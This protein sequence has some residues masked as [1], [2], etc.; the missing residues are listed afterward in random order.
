MNQILK[1]LLF[2]A[3]H[4]IDVG[5]LAQKLLCGY[6]TICEAPHASVHDAK[7][8]EVLIDAFSEF[9]GEIV[10][11]STYKWIKYIGDLLSGNPVDDFYGQHFN[12]DTND[13]D[14]IINE[15]SQHEWFVNQMRNDVDSETINY[16]PE[17]AKTRLDIHL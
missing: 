10:D 17:I 12:F 11:G 13:I 9:D 14:Q 15:L 2:E 6:L 4:D 8:H 7:G 3:T 1:R 16:L 5:K